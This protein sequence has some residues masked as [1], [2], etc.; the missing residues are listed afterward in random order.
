[1]SFRLKLFA[2]IAIAVMLTATI[3]AGLDYVY[4]S[5]HQRLDA[6][7]SADLTVFAEAAI[8]AVD[9]GTDPLRFDD[10]ALEALPRLRGERLRVTAGDQV[11]LTYGGLYPDD[12]TGWATLERFLG[13]GYRLEAALPLGLVERVLGSNLV[14]DLLDLPLFFALAF[15]V[16][17]V[18]TRLVMRPV[19]E[20]TT[21][22][23][24]ISRQQFPEPVTVPAGGDEL[25]DMARSFNVMSASIQG[26]I[27]RE[28]T[29]TRYASH[30]LRTPLSALK[31][32]AEA[33]ELGLE[34]PDEALP[35]LQRNV[36]RME[37]VLTALLALA[38]S[39]EHDPARVSL[40]PL[41][42]ETLDALE[43]SERQRV[44]VIDR[45]L[46]PA[47]VSDAAL[48]RQA[49]TNLVDNALKYSRGA[50]TVLLDDADGKG[51]VR[52]CDEGPGI[53]EHDI[54]R[55]RRPFTRGADQGDGLGLGLA[56]TDNIARSI[57]GGLEFLNTPA[58]LEVS[59]TVPLDRGPDDRSLRR[60]RA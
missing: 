50:V 46:G 52:V 1:M 5:W 18:L 15:G 8:G 49:V 58:G 32:H 26:L 39:A 30:E 57:R 7:T 12:V 45:L 53:A 19:G 29:F 48:V 22:L 43:P 3:E 13:S 60:T 17:F 21:A 16:A 34:S 24:Q 56:L 10:R 14:L 27:E 41:V 31:M 4:D 28:R 2:S 20:L 59:L 33:L 9:V 37:A 6:R 25:S 44:R 55:V 47:T 42:V 11:V 23:D 36:E 51:V 54:E 35:V 40:H 38:R